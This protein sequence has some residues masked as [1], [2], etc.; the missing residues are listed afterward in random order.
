MHWVLIVGCFAVASL[1]WLLELRTAADL[2]VATSPSGKAFEVLVHRDGVYP[3]TRS[4]VVLG[5]TTI[6]AT[7]Y[8]Y[9]RNRGRPW[10]YAVTVRKKTSGLGLGFGP[11]VIREVFPDRQLAELEAEHLVLQLSSGTIDLPDWV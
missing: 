8:L 11:P 1:V 4:D 6:W 2:L 3:H 5:L 7:L 9:A 10:S